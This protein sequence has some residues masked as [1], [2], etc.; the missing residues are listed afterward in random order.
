MIKV[1]QVF[2]GKRV[3]NPFFLSRVHLKWKKNC[4]YLS[5]FKEM[6]EQVSLEMDSFSMD[7]KHTQ[8]HSS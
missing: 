7:V 8:L 1:H 2:P 4:Y 6:S 5:S 3:E